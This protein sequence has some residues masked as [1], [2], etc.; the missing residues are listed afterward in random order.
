MHCCLIIF[1]I[2]VNFIFPTILSLCVSF[3]YWRS[4]FPKLQNESNDFN[5]VTAHARCSFVSA[6]ANFLLLCSHRN[7]RRPCVLLFFPLS[8]L[9]LQWRARWNSNTFPA[10]AIIASVYSSIDTGHPASV[11]VHQATCWNTFITLR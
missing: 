8:K 7:T 2:R 11:L 1:L 6:D 9:V 3:S 5:V 10:C 4:W